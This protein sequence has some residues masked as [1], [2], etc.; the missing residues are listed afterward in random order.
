M[1]S[2][3]DYALIAPNI[4]RFDDSTRTY[5]AHENGL[6]H[7]ASPC[8]AAMSGLLDGE[9]RFQKTG[10]TPVQVHVGDAEVRASN[11]GRTQ[12]VHRTARTTQPVPLVGDEGLEPPTSSV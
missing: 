6:D 7:Q 2:T 3:P 9:Y 10:T 4:P 11:T 12:F 5:G 1:V 8:I